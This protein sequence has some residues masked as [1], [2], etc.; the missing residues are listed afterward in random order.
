MP[1]KT[2]IDLNSNLEQKVQ[3]VIGRNHAIFMIGH[4]LS[5]VDNG[6]LI[7]RVDG[8]RGSEMRDEIVLGIEHVD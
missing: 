4:R 3:R 5:T 2:T 6:E 1:D 7:I 8:S